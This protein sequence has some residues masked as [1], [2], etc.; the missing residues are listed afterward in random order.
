MKY[1]V[2]AVDFDGTIVTE[3]Y[4]EVGTLIPAAKQTL[5]RFKEK[6]GYIVVWTCREG[7]TLKDSIEFLNDWNI[8]YDAVN[9][10]L[11]HRI[12]QYGND[13]RKI[14]ADLYIDDRTPNGVDWN[15]IAK[16]LEV[17]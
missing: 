2:I 10:N 11:P 14:G 3:N 12:K 4:P 5:K 7:K 6:G 8:P 9:E 13:P 16:L 1:N 15:Y 17:E